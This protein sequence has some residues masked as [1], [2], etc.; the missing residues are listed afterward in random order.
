MTA[1]HHDEA[2]V[3]GAGVIGLSMATKGPKEHHLQQGLEPEVR[4]EGALW[5]PPTRISDSHSFLVALLADAQLNS[6]TRLSLSATANGGRTKSDEGGNVAPIQC[7]GTL[8][9][10]I[11]SK[12]RHGCELCR[13]VCS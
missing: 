5:L 2:D 10:L 4:F 9:R 3:I 7:T 13:T 8:C 12:A 6:A 11:A 1:A